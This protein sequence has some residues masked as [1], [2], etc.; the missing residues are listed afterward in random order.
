[1]KLSITSP[2]RTATPDSAMNPT[3]AET[4]NVMSRSHKAAIAAGERQRD[5]AEHEQRVAGGAQGAQ[6]K[7]EY[8][9]KAHRH[10]NREALPRCLEILELSAP[11]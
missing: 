6:Q 8:Q 3:A 11:C 5:R 4:E 10:H 2:L 7:E 1:M 9:C